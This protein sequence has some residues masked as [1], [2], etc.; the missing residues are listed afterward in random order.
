[1]E[2]K[3]RIREYMGWFYPEELVNNKWFPLR[4]TGEI[5]GCVLSGYGD[6]KIIRDVVRYD[7]LQHGGL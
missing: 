7:C 6:I 1:M 2:R 4:E 3:F 5:N